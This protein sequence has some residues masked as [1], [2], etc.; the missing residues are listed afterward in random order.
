MIMRTGQD[1]EVVDVIH[2]GP[3]AITAITAIM[4]S[5]P[6]T[7]CNEFLLRWMFPDL[8]AH[9]CRRSLYQQFSKFVD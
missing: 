5:F 8:R 9:V 7:L 3:V 1:A 2:T 6:H 4:K